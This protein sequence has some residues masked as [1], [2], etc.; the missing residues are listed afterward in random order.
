MG[1]GKQ[2]KIN[3]ELATPFLVIGGE[4]RLKQNLLQM[5]FL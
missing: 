4:G 5:K 3:G 1:W 2:S